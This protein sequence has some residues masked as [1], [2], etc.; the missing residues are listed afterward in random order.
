MGTEVC[1][2]AHSP[3]GELSVGLSSVIYVLTS[4]N[5]KG[6]FPGQDGVAGSVTSSPH[7]LSLRTNSIP[8][9][10]HHREKPLPLREINCSYSQGW[11]S[12]S[13]NFS[14]VKGRHQ[15]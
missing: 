14:Y 12:S 9:K 10:K 3:F 2:G 13:S 1:F 11:E 4:L 15:I 5:L 6:D 8:A 7:T